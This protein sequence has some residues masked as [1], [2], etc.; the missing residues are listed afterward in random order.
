MA[1]SQYPNRTQVY[2]GDLEIVI[3]DYLYSLDR[4]KAKADHIRAGL[5][6]HLIEHAGF[7]QEAFEK[8]ANNFAQNLKDEN[9]KAFFEKELDRLLGRDTTPK[10]LPCPV[11]ADSLKELGPNLNMD[12]IDSS[13][14][15]RR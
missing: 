1:K 12:Q 4:N 3:L 14:F 8:V 9:R 13:I 11:I 15:A 10:E 7:N 5:Q 6:K 2:L